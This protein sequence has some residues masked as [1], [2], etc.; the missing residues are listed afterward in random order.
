MSNAGLTTWTDA[1][2]VITQRLT[3][4]YTAAYAGNYGSS[5]TQVWH[6]TRRRTKVYDYVGIDESAV[7]DCVYFLNDLWLRRIPKVEAYVYQTSTST[8]SKPTD[9]SQ[10]D[11]PLVARIVPNRIGGRLWSINVQVEETV[12]IPCNGNRITNIN[13][14]QAMFETTFGVHDYDGERG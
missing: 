7:Q 11:F 10:C 6:Y 3:S 4:E 14:I 13:T 2:R 5:S 9:D 12:T 8:Y 1:N